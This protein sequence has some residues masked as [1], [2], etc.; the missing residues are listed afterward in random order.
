MGYFYQDGV[1]ERGPLD[2]K[3]RHSP[4]DVGLAQDEERR[5]PGLLRVGAASSPPRHRVGAAQLA[6][7][8]DRAVRAGRGS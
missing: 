1:F 5:R 2:Q 3:L 4:D 6:G 8:A 7:R